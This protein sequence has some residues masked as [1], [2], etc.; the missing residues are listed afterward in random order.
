MVASGTMPPVETAGVG[1]GVGVVVWLVNGR[2]LG[3]RSV[4]FSVAVPVP[5]TMPDT[6][7]EAKKYLFNP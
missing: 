1:G 4:L 7:Q 5:R 2:R 6:Q 3:P